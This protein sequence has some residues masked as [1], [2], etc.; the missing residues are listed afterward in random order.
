MTENPYRAPP[1]FHEPVDTEFGLR[2]RA[3]LSFRLVALVLLAPAVYNYW[4]FDT[5]AIASSRLPS[6]LTAVY[7]AANVVALVVGFTLIWFLGLPLLEAVSRLLRVVFAKG[8]DT[9]AWQRV[10]YRSMNRAVILASIGAALWVIWVFGFYQIGV[11]FY[12]ISWAI[13]VPAHLLAACWYVPLIYCWYRM[14]GSQ[15]TH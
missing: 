3:L 2:R 12:V 14:S 8:V 11:N 1:L 9:A 15:L 5:Q 10:L 6:D 7:R 13:G 4:A